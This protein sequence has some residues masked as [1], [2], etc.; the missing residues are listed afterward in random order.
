[1]GRAERVHRTFVRHASYRGRKGSDILQK[2]LQFIS[3]LAKGNAY[4]KISPVIR[5]DGSV[6]WGSMGIV[7]RYVAD[8]GFT[9]RQTAAVRICSAAAVLILFLLITD[10]RKLK[11]EKQD[12]KWFL[13]TGLG[14][15]FINNLAYAETVQRASLSVAVVLLYTAPFFVMIM[16]ILFQGKLTLQKVV[17]LLLSFAGCVLVVGLSGV[18]AGSSGALRC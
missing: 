7:T 15:L 5:I 8:I 17:A 10:H 3:D 13:G 4:E 2:C 16:S 6:L 9:T 11:I 12:L 1:M 18:N 14:S